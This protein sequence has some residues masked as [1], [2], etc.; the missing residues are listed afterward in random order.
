MFDA[1]MEHIRS[2][3]LPGESWS[4]PIFLRDYKQI[5]SEKEQD[6]TLTS[7]QGL[8]VAADKSGTLSAFELESGYCLWSIKLD[9]GFTASPKS[10]DVKGGEY[11]CRVFIGG[12]SGVFYCVNASDGSI[13][14]Q[15]R[16]C[17]KIRSTAAI[18]SV[19]GLDNVCLYVAAYG[20]RL[21]ALNTE[22]GSVIWS[23]YL[24]K[25]ELHRGTKIGVVSSPLLADVD[26]DGELEI[27]IGTRSRRIFCFSAKSGK[28]KWF[29]ELKYDPDSS[30]SFAMQGKHPVVFV[31]GGE[32]TSGYG[33]NALICL[34]GNNGKLAWKADV[35]GGMDS[36][37]VIGDVDGDGKDE[38]VIA[39]L[40]DASCYAFSAMSGE[41]KWQYRFGPTQYCTHTKSNVCTKADGSPYFTENA[42]CRSYSTALP[43]KS[44]EDDSIDLC[45]GS[46][47]GKLVVLKGKDGKE[48]WCFQ[49]EGFFRASPI[50]FNANE[51]CF[52][53][54]ISKSTLHIFQSKNYRADWP[55]FKGGASNLAEYP[56]F[57]QKTQQVKLPGQR[58]LHV[59]LFWHWIVVDAFRYTLFQLENRVFNKFGFKLRKYYY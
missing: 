26:L 12:E 30:P 16:L 47:N 24:P 40:A 3:R 25:H 50:G 6:E 8:I 35:G 57:S 39:S 36:C 23:S 54:A 58:F 9:I 56:R 46:N 27:V 21:Y 53:V 32:H 1:H 49:G 15:T 5:D 17:G 20:A 29:R 43:L 38:V 10:L 22:D 41:V 42:I 37:P 14:W 19:S 11:D 45:F 7:D 33:D 55:M 48:N 2:H 34:Q 4:T 51:G 18:G 44:L 52:V 13:V 28:L 59:K 31:G